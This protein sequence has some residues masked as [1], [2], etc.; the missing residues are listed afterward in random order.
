LWKEL[1]FRFLVGGLF[2]STFALLGD[3]FK[4]KSFAG[5]FGSAPSVALATLALTISERGRGYASVEARSMT[6]GAIAFLVCAYCLSWTT[7]RRHWSAAWSSALGIV[8]WLVIALGIWSV[9]L[10]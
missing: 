2:V 6:V 8:L 1:I 5:L 9:V 4:P 7:M 10:R 3:L